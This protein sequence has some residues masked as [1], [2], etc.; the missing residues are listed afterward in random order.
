M[1]YLFDLAARDLYGP[2][3]SHNAP[4]SFATMRG[5]STYEIVNDREAQRDF[6][7]YDLI[8]VAVEYR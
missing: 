3:M 6:I 1:F 7:S 5:I 4:H 8:L 2:F